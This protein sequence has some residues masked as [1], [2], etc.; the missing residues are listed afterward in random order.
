MVSEKALSPLNYFFYKCG[1]SNCWLPLALEGHGLYVGFS[2]SLCPAEHA[3]K[4]EDRH[5]IAVREPE[6]QYQKLTGLDDDHIAWLSHQANRQRFLLI[7][8]SQSDLIFWEVVGTVEVHQP[9]TRVFER[10]REIWEGFPPDIKK[11]EHYKQIF[12]NRLVNPVFKTLPSRKLVAVPR[13]ELYSS[14]DS[15]AVYQSLN[16]GTCRAIW[17]IKG[18]TEAAMPEKIAAQRQQMILGKS[19]SEETNFAAFVR[20]YLNSILQHKL[21]QQRMQIPGNVNG[22]LS[23]ASLLRHLSPKD[24]RVLVLSTLNP[25]LVET[26]ALYFCLDLGLVAD[27]GTGKGIDVIDIRARAES[28]G[29]A[30]QAVEWL[31][32]LASEEIQVNDAV[33]ETLRK[34]QVLELQCKAAHDDLVARD[35]LLYFGYRRKQNRNL[36]VNTISL[37]ELLSAF[38]RKPWRGGLLQRFV[39]LQGK[40]LSQSVYS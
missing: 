35:N 4:K 31:T 16:R 27:I 29:A 36:Q 26:A 24:R 8:F 18:P 38:G 22:Q 40:V 17:R 15:L 2:D 34:D 20:L 30:N 23:L 9:G 13:R 3:S 12:E 28:K 7:T 6:Q 37:P 25:I 32:E 39:K 5:R 1:T 10:A 19:D 33:R 11:H 21:A 14:I